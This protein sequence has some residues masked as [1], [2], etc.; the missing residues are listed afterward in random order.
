[1]MLNAQVFKQQHYLMPSPAFF[2]LIYRQIFL[3]LAET[4]EISIDASTNTL[5][6][7]KY[8]LFS[9]KMCQTNTILMDI[10]TEFA[11]MV[12]KIALRAKLRKALLSQ[13]FAINPHQYILFEPLPG[14]RWFNY[15]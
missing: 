15:Y 6:S 13:G 5:K 2:K 8:G 10:G 11:K 14:V 3:F 9:T 4:S 1:M 7:L 12:K